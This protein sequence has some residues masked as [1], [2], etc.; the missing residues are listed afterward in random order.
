MS[1]FS[2]RLR[3]GYSPCALPQC[4]VWM[5]KESGRLDRQGVPVDLVSFKGAETAAV[6][7]R[8]GRAQ[9]AGMGTIAAV[10]AYARGAKDLVLIGGVVNSPALSVLV[11]PNIHKPE[12]LKGRQVAITSFEGPTAFSM[13]WILKKWELEPM[14][15]VKLVH[16]GNAM[17]LVIAMEKGTTAA[18]IADAVGTSM[19]LKRGFR[20]LV[21]LPEAGLR[22]QFVSLVTTR[23]FAQ[24]HE[25][26]MGLV[27]K[28]YL[29]GI[30]DL[31]QDKVKSFEIL[32]KYLNVR[33]PEALE[34]AYEALTRYVPDSGEV[35]LEGI[36][37]IIRDELTSEESRG[38]QIED[39]VDLAYLSRARAA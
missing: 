9:L 6:G 31:K 5:L 21:D 3:V 32:R 33:D 12:D 27:M 13:S 26:L 1:A 8:Y 22:Y 11:H 17:S 19:L 39:L 24:E 20:K 14:K 7:I 23:S 4:P 36:Q 18:T 16:V 15:D 29:D 30:Y 38:I 28:A 37:T 2:T 10:R 34:S 35:D 25:E